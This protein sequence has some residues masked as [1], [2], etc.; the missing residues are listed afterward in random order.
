MNIVLDGSKKKYIIREDA[1]INIQAEH[2]DQVLIEIQHASRI[3]LAGSFKS[4]EC[5]VI[6]LN[7]NDV[8][9][10]I[11]EAY[12]VEGG[13]VEVA[14]GH[15]TACNV[16]YSS[17]TWLDDDFSIMKIHSYSLCKAQIKMK[18]EVINQGKATTGEMNHYVVCLENSLFDLKA[19]GK[20]VNGAIGSQNHQTSKCLTFDQLKKATILPELLIDENDVQ[21]SHAMSIGQVN[22]EQMFY[23]Q[24]RGLSSNEISKLVTLGYVMPLARLLD[25]EAQNEALS[26]VIEE[27]VNVLCWM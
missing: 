5:K 7:I 1:E 17:T 16:E 21:A 13:S 6:V 8:D 4:V 3:K 2:N 20:I 15:F 14:Y 18:Q 26:H 19:T 23:L 27:R 24:S 9:C 11:D 10:V 25:D 12:H 22:E